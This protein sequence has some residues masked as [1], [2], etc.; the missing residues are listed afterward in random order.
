MGTQYTAFSENT[1]F[2]KLVFLNLG[3]RSS[4]CHSVSTSIGK[5]QFIGQILSSSNSV[6]IYIGTV[7]R[8]AEDPA[9]V[10]G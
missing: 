5:R 4:S 9:L 8:P 6:D 3:K 7:I 2:Q 1:C 10:N